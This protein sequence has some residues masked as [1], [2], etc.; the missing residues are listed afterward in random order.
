MSIPFSHKGHQAFCQMTQVR[1]IADAQP[2]ALQNAEPLRD[3]IH[4]LT[5]DGQKEAH[6]ARV[7]LSRLYFH[8]R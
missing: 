1:E 6:E 2:L 4:P 5:V 8:Q 7:S 3:L